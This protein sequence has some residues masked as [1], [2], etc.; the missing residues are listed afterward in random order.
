MT[1]DKPCTCPKVQ[2]DG[3]VQRFMLDARCPVHGQK[4]QRERV[5]QNCKSCTCRFPEDD[6]NVLDR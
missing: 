5:H 4:P 2:K 6:S 1:P 3:H